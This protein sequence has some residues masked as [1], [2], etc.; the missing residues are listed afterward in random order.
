MKSQA[1]IKIMK[2][3]KSLGPGLKKYVF[4]KKISAHSIFYTPKTL[5]LTF[6]N[7]R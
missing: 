2:R 4:N 1:F 6:K 5:T 3:F 7:Q